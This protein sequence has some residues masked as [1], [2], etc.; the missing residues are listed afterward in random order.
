[1]PFKD[2]GRRAYRDPEGGITVVASHLERNDDVLWDLPVQGVLGEEPEN[3]HL[4]SLS[5]SSFSWG[6]HGLNP[7][8]SQTSPGT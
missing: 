3:K 6:S 2:E 5:P 4:D 7:T 8:G 1:M